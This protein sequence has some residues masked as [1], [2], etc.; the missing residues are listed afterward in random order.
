MPGIPV[1][2][3]AA[4]ALAGA[5]LAVPFLGVFGLAGAPPP[6]APL[7]AL[8]GFAAWHGRT[9][10]LLALVAVAVALAAIDRPWREG[11]RPGGF[12]RRARWIVERFPLAALY[13]AVVVVGLELVA[14]L[15]RLLGLPARP[16]DAGVALLALAV[17]TAQGVPKR[18]PA[19]L[20]G[21]LA[22]VAVA[23][24]LAAP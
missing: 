16:W 2:P 7:E 9:A 13:V 1:D 10:T 6:F 14:S 4:A 12:P 20:V 17:V 23:H 19:A 15:H 11:G 24:D 3:R 18:G 8:H 22:A 21:F 5:V